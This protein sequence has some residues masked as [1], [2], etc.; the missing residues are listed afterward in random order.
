MNNEHIAI[1]A[2]GCFWCT[3][4]VFSQLKGV[5][6]VASGYIGGHT[7]NPTYKDIC[8]GDTGHAE[9]IKITFD[10]AKVSFDTLLEIFFI[11]HDPTMRNRQGNDIGTQYRS[12]VFCQDEA[13]RQS[14]QDMIARLNAE[15]IWQAPIVT[16][17]NGTEIFYQAEDYHQYYYD[18]NPNQPYR[19][20]VAGPKVAKIRAKYTSLLKN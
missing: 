3:E 17:I 4:P 5:K 10:P 8:N 7:I 6:S 14:T 18:K 19:M 1:F 15:Q 9:G 11:S 13:Q 20:A 16:Q 12:A 2:G